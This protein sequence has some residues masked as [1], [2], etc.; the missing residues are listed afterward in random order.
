[1]ASDSTDNSSEAGSGGETP[2]QDDVPDEEVLLYLSSGR[3]PRPD[4]SDLSGS[5][6]G[7]RREDESFWEEESLSEDEKE[8]EA[9]FALDAPP[10]LEES[11]QGILSSTIST[12][13]ALDPIEQK[14]VVED[15]LSGKRL[16][17][18]LVPLFP[19]TATALFLVVISAI[20]GI[21][22][23]IQYARGYL[24]PFM[25]ANGIFM[26]HLWAYHVGY[27]T[28][29]RF[30]VLRQ[31]LFITVLSGFMSFMIW[32]M[33]SNPPAL[34]RV[35]ARL[36]GQYSLYLWVALLSQSVGGAMILMHWL[37]LG[38]GYRELDDPVGKA[39]KEIAERQGR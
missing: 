3:I 17:P 1:M 29:R 16:L 6:D 30:L 13:K 36:S 14:G 25:V 24:I 11:E 10:E 20:C 5:D 18:G 8:L 31:T 9:L 34:A 28:R 12:L 37:I 23:S 32:D 33:I 38:R 26:G 4:L 7:E 35:T 21:L 2:A 15:P 22:F 19:V 27:R 39:R